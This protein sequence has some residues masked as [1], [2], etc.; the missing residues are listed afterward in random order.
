M[1]RDYSHGMEDN[2]RTWKLSK[3]Q[4][5]V[6]QHFVFD[7]GLHEAAQPWDKKTKQPLNQH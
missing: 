1:R 5:F 2:L 6:L 3:L 7:P 4:L